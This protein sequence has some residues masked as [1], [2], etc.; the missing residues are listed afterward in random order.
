MTTAE[1]I[2]HELRRA[3]MAAFYQFLQAVGSIT[4]DA[5]R[6]DTPTPDV[7]REL[8][9]QLARL[10]ATLSTDAGAPIQTTSGDQP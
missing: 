9:E 6:M 3:R 8:Q 2:T 4:S 5:I 7:V 10:E 1:P